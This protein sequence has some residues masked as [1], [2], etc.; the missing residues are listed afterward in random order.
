MSGLSSFFQVLSI[1]NPTLTPTSIPPLWTNPLGINI[2]SKTNWLTPYLPAMGTNKWIKC[3]WM[4]VK[5]KYPMK[6]DH[7]EYI[8]FYVV[9]FTCELMLQFLASTALNTPTI[10]INKHALYGV[11][12]GT[13]L[14][15]RRDRR[16]SIV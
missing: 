1:P 15:N 9:L 6:W 12:G 3:L 10:P 4:R 14:R 13:P 11:K 16:T 7:L 8:I 2:F 5:E